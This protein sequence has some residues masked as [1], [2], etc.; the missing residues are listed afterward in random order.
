MQVG[1]PIWRVWRGNQVDRE[2]PYEV[3]LSCVT[4]QY[5]DAGR[6]VYALKQYKLKWWVH[7]KMRIDYRY[8]YERMRSLCCVLEISSPPLYLMKL[9]RPTTSWLWN[10]LG[11]TG[12]QIKAAIVSSMSSS[13]C[14]MKYKYSTTYHNPRITNMNATRRHSSRSEGTYRQE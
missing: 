8:M 1:P 10:Q 14:P 9:K 12:I 2:R 4:S 6:W 11:P 13:S 7:V 3:E 5:I